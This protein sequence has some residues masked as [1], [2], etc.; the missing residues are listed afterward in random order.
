MQK[1]IMVVLAALTA[2]PVLAQTSPQMTIDL[3]A[4]MDQQQYRICN[5]RPARPAWMDDVHPR[6]AYKTVTLM[7]LYELRA[8]EDVVQAGSCDCNVRFPTWDRASA[9]FNE[10]YVTA[11]AA[12]HTATQRDIRRQ[13]NELRFAVQEICD[14]QGNW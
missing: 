4:T 1:I 14:A 11:S 8:W 6:E 3:T 2:C 10:R 5:D 9:E 12:E 13:R 7:D